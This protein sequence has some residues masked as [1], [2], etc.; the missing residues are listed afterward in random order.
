MRHG[1][2]PVSAGPAPQQCVQCTCVRRPRRGRSRPATMSRRVQYSVY[3]A[4]VVRVSVEARWRPF[5]EAASARL[6]CVSHSPGAPPR[7][8]R[9]P[10]SHKH[11]PPI[12]CSSWFWPGRGCFGP[13]KTRC[14]CLSCR[15]EPGLAPPTGDRSPPAGSSACVH[16]YVL[17]GCRRL[18]GLHMPHACCH[19]QPG[20]LSCVS[21]APPPLAPR[22]HLP[23]S[24]ALALARLQSAQ[25]LVFPFLQHV[26]ALFLHFG[27]RF[28]P[29]PSSF[30][31][32]GPDATPLEPTNSHMPPGGS[33]RLD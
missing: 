5:L 1:R 16:W 31:F 8:P 33:A 23:S 29:Q 14:L 4:Q 30:R 25:L 17:C 22:L 28:D 21:P 26:P 32:R 7:P 27:G 24:Q 20:F 9:P 10:M 18:G 19:C 3:V 6:S 11:P 2:A 15:S 12:C 13:E